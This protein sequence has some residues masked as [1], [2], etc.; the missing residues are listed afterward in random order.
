[1][2]LI[3][4]LDNRRLPT[5]TGE[6]LHPEHTF[7]KEK[8]SITDLQDRFVQLFFQ[9]VRVHYKSSTKMKTLRD[10]GKKYKDLLQDIDGFCEY[11]EDI[12]RIRKMCQALITHTRDCVKGKGER[13]L[14]YT[15]LISYYEY[16]KGRIGMGRS[17][18]TILSILHYWAKG[19]KRE[20]PPGS[21]GDITKFCCFLKEWVAT[22]SSTIPG[23]YNQIVKDA[24]QILA[25]QIHIDVTSENP[26]LASKWAPR[27]GSK[28]QRWL[29][30]RFVREMMP[31]LE[32]PM[33][34][35]VTHPR[36]LSACKTIRKTVSSLSRKTQTL[37]I[38]QTEKRWR[39]IN[40][41]SVPAIA[42]QKQKK[43]LLNLP[44]KNGDSE[45]RSE[46]EDRILCAKNF[47]TFIEDIRRGTT[48]LKAERTSIYDLIR[49]A[50]LA[51]EG[52]YDADARLLL[53][54]QWRSN[55]KQITARLPPMIPMIDVSGSM[56]CDKSTPLFYAIGLGLRVSE[57]THP[58]FRNRVLTFSETPSWIRLPEPPYRTDPEHEGSFIKRVKMIQK[59]P[60][61]MNT[62]F[63]Q[64]LNMIL[65]A[66]VEN[67][68]P[69]REAKGMVLAVFS[70]MQI[71]A[72]VTDRRIT[73]QA[74]H[75]T[76]QKMYEE[77]GYTAPHILYWN[78]RTTEGFPCV[79]TEKNITML[80]GFSPILLNVF[81]T[82]GIEALH[83]YTPYCMITEMLESPRNLPERTV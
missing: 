53:E 63:Y 40:P 3:D 67:R 36:F 30:Y 11:N 13:D 44:R 38:Y 12:I 21:W 52:G 64:A 5:G 73:P 49:D 33:I 41:K 68:I 19:H 26:S 17:R 23:E 77:K 62:D 16:Q 2:S 48:K 70:D 54:E 46:T 60:W 47:T 25:N 72:A 39:E 61:G 50:T 80:S 65:D 82:K 57:R 79:T 31:A 10:I 76:I 34:T 7:S 29:F 58:L 35:P 28:K 42:L 66:L 20:T 43:A 37:E 78:L 9:M 55:G 69:P 59:A 6:N 51:D 74:M 81:Q 14:A 1:M 4:G 83:K 75:T 32:G 8:A 56:C 22:E 18:S 27:E 71:D 15:L 45:V 24:L